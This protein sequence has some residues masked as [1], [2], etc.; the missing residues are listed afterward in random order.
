VTEEKIPVRLT[1]AATAYTQK[2]VGGM[3]PVETV[4][5]KV[6]AAFLAG[7]RWM[8]VRAWSEGAAWAAVEIGAIDHEDQSWEAP[9]DNP[10]AR[11]DHAT[12]DIK[13]LGQCPGCDEYHN[14]NLDRA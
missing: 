1:T 5:D 7:A 3:Q 14:R 10:Y 12:R 11:H 6:Y 9:G 4:G 13:P 8:A 2:H